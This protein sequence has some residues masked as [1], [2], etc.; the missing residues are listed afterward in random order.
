MLPTVLPGTDH[1]TALS[2][3]DRVTDTALV[4]LV[5]QAVVGFASVLVVLSLT[6]VSLGDPIEPET[7]LAA[8]LGAA[9]A[10]VIARVRG[11]ADESDAPTETTDLPRDPL[12]AA[13]IEAALVASTPAAVGAEADAVAT[14]DGARPRW[15]Q[16]LDEVRG[17]VEPELPD[18][19]WLEAA[20]D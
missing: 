2:F 3:R 16:R 4:P 15:I 20:P 10:A 12:V 5:S 17:D 14:T 8:A 19:G 18:E 7:S 13:A 6:A 11:G 1:G 9:L